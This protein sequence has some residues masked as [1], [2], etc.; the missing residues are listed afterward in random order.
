MQ[1]KKLTQDYLK[2]MQKVEIEEA[3]QHD[4]GGKQLFEIFEMM[5]CLLLYS[6]LYRFLDI[7]T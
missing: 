1:R 7:L 2:K 6:D 5:G 4:N 3:S